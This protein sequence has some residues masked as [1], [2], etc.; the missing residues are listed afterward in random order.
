MS[1]S[2]GANEPGATAAETNS[3]DQQVSSSVIHNHTPDSE[4]S[5][6]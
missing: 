4:A 6:P 1:D 3:G 2:E 5:D